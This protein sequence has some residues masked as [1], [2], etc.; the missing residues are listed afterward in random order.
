M[1]VIQKC[2]ITPTVPGATECVKIVR[3]VE[4]MVIADQPV[5]NVLSFFEGAAAVAAGALGHM[6]NFGYGWPNVSVLREGSSPRG[7]PSVP[8]FPTSFPA[9]RLDLKNL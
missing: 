9:K 7:A 6:C 1:P 8:L 4:L 2:V 5:P 3:S